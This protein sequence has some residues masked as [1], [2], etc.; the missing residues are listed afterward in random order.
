M[1]GMKSKYKDAIEFIDRIA[2]QQEKDGVWKEMKPKKEMTAQDAWI[3][4]ARGEFVDDG[5]GIHRIDGGR[6]LWWDRD[7]WHLT[8]VINPG[9][10][11][12][13]PDPS[14]PEIKEVQSDIDKAAIYAIAKEICR[15]LDQGR[16][17]LPSELILIFARW[18]G[19]NFQRKEVK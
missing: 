9:P 6:L 18:V 15:D 7:S 16:T 17:I 5:I 19:E 1:Q 11:S 12:I 13:V 10:Y 4:M 14:K 3:A 8:A 2:E